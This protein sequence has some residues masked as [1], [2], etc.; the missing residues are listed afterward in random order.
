VKLDDK[1]WPLAAQLPFGVPPVDEGPSLEPIKRKDFAN[2]AID[3]G[4][5]L[6]PAVSTAAHAGAIRAPLLAADP[7]QSALD[8]PNREIVMPARITAATTIQAL[9]LTNG[10]TLDTR[11]KKAAAKHLPDAAKDPAA[12]IE[13]IYRSLL[14]RAPAAGE[15]EIAVELLGA[16]P[17]AEALADFLW[18]IV[19][20]PEFQLIN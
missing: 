2:I 14:S 10:S 9:E 20:L 16:E 18:A 1:Q 15:R 19:N 8:R 12:W 6:R 17:K 4:P 7:L 11:L 13:H 3:F 5:I